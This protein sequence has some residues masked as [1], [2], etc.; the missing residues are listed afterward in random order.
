[1]SEKN[2]SSSMKRVDKNLDGILYKWKMT[3]TWNSH[4]AS[5]LD[6]SKRKKIIYKK[7][8]YMSTNNEW[9][10]NIKNKMSNIHMRRYALPHAF[11]FL[12]SKLHHPKSLPP[13]L[14]NTNQRSS[15]YASSELQLAK[16]RKRMDETVSGGKMNLQTKTL[17]IMFAWCSL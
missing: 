8:E 12:A 1:M 2:G 15:Q 9:T 6:F 14:H 4:Y 17:I 16:L 3:V 13:Y 7:M 11:L 10:V 5:S